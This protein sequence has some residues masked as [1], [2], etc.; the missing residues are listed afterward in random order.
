MPFTFGGATPTPQQQ[1]D[2]LPA[3]DE[4]GQ[5]RRAQRLEPARDAAFA[6]DAPGALRFRETRELRWRR[7]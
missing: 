4:R 5:R 3:A 2:L 1:V 7:P 6:D